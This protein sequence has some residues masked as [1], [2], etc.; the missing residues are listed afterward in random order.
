MDEEQGAEAFFKEMQKHRNL[1]LTDH[2]T[3]FSSHVLVH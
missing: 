2:V 3:C 1:F